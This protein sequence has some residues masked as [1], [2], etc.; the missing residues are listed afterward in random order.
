[1]DALFYEQIILS[2]PGH[3]VRGSS[4]SYL[5]RQFIFILPLPS[6]QVLPP[7]LFFLIRQRVKL[8]PVNAILIQKLFNIPL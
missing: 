6:L 4:F 7:A 8:N 3:K 5:S 2:C 1:M